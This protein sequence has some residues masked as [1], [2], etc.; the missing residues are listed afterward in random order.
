M[1]LDDFYTPTPLAEQL[2]EYVPFTRIS[3]IADFAAGDGE[4]LKTASKKF[5]KAKYYAN[6][7]SKS[8]I[9]KISKEHKHWTVLNYDFFDDNQLKSSKILQ[10]LYGKLDLIILN[11]P[12][13]CRKKKLNDIL[14]AGK[15]FRSSPAL[16]FVAKSVRF[17]SPEGMLFAILPSSV[18]HS[19]RDSDLWDELKHK[20][21]LKI[22]S[23]IPRIRFP[24]CSPNIIF[25]SLNFNDAKEIDLEI[26]PIKCNLKNISLKRGSIS[27][28]KVNNTGKYPLIHTTNLQKNKIIITENRT[29]SYSSIIKGPSILIPRVGNPSKEK[30]CIYKYKKYIGIS[31]CIIAINLTSTKD[32]IKLK[33]L[34]L[35]N[36]DSFKEIY[37][38]TGAKYTTIAK[39]KTILSLHNE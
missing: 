5:P 7:I 25:V 14:F 36:W 2:L 34:I 9:E 20:F 27:M 12:F 32:A 21:N 11:P 19:H 3:K 18:S 16:T 13:S 38:G 22:V 1:Q 31:D 17:L 33:N 28:P 26:K 6:D 30:I 8:A 39:I 4:L 23:N 24:G 29:D 15:L 37:N 10:Q 35:D